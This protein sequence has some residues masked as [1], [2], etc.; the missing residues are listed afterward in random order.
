MVEQKKKEVTSKA[1]F[2]KAVAD[3]ERDARESTVEVEASTS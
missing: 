1:D 2:A 3:K